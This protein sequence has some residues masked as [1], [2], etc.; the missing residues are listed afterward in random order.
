MLDLCRRSIETGHRHFFY[1]GAPGVADELADRLTKRFPGLRV[2]GTYAPSRLAVGE[3]EN[4]AT[5][6]RIN[7]A[8]P[9]IVWVGL[10]TPKQDWWV[11]NH[12]PLLNAPA[13][14]AIGAAF[15]FH[16][17]RVR[18]APRWMQRSGLEW[19]FRFSQDPRRLWKRYTVVNGQFVAKSVRQALSHR[20]AGQ[21]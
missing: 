12:R 21:P 20:A 19:A 13:L 15:D 10:G 9:D 17:G 11:A 16:S 2:A 7:A 3:L 18:Q 5:I 6:E 14:I 4:P 8:E 1:G